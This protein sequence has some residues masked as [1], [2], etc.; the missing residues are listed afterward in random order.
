MSKDKNRLHLQVYTPDRRLIGHFDGEFFYTN[1]S[2]DL[3]VDGNK[4]YTKEMPC[5]FVGDFDGREI[6]MLNGVIVC[7]LEI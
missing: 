7:Y 3:R 4:V 1:P 5:K 2:I 6:K